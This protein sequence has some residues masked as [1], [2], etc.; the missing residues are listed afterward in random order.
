MSVRRLGVDAVVMTLAQGLQVG[1]EG[2]LVVTSVTPLI[3]RVDLTD[4]AG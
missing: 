3:T 2:N 1:H 4:L